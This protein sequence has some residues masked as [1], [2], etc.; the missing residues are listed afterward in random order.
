MATITMDVG[1]APPRRR[2]S[3]EKFWA[4][5]LIAPYVVVFAL[6]VVYQ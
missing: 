6:F 3:D 5:V 4:I 2:M 1:A